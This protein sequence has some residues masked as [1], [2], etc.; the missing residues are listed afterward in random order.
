MRVSEVFSHIPVEDADRWR[1][2]L[3]SLCQ[4]AIVLSVLLFPTAVVPA[5][6]RDHLTDAE[7]DL[8]RYYQELDK[9]VDVFIKAADR[10]FALINGT[11]QPPTK[12]TS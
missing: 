1:V 3:A 8:V 9:R 10:R 6:T 12:K 7:T 4:G 2:A 11:A 5:Q